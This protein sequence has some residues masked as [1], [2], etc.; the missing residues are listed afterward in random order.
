MEKRLQ[1]HDDSPL[2][3]RGIEQA[4]AIISTLQTLAP[5]RVVA[6]DLGR[7]QET[8]RLIGYDEPQLDAQLRELN[9]GTWTGLRKDDLMAEHPDLYHQWRAGLYVPKGGEAWSDFVSRIITTLSSRVAAG[10]GDLLAIV[11]S[12]VVRAAVYGFLGLKPEQL[13]PVTPGTLTIL[14]FND[15]DPS[16]PPRLE[17]Y[18]IGAFAPDTEAAD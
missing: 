8:A 2:S 10:K 17:A 6:S 18:N 13:L 1:G 14:D 15:E 9:M 5:Q 16:L 7:V 4:K 11:H 3:P 12:G